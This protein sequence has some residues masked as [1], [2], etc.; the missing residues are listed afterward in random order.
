MKK[1][2][3]NWEKG[4]NLLFVNNS[5]NPWLFKKIE[6]CLEL[7]VVA[8]SKEIRDFIRNLLASERSR[9]QKETRGRVDDFRQTLTIYDIYSD[10][11]DDN[12]SMLKQLIE[13]TRSFLDAIRTLEKDK[14]P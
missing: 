4:F 13:D 9:W 3:A 11:R 2:D 5:R 1:T 8:R 12:N 7:D 6:D 10:D 14:K